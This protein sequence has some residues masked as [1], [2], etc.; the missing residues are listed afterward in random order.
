MLAPLVNSRTGIS[1]PSTK[2]R[3]G[4][5]TDT[6]TPGH[7]VGKASARMRIGWARSGTEC[8]IRS[9]EFVGRSSVIGRVAPPW[10]STIS[11]TPSPPPKTIRA[12]VAI[13]R[14]GC[15]ADHVCNINGECGIPRQGCGGGDDR[16]DRAAAGRHIG[17]D[18][19][20]RIELCPPEFER[21]DADCESECTK[22]NV[23]VDIAIPV[24]VR[25]TAARCLWQPR[26]RYRSGCSSRC[27][28]F[29][30]KSPSPPVNFTQTPEGISYRH[31]G[32]EEKAGTG[33]RQRGLRQ[34]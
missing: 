7:P 16:R 28:S 23:G 29:Q 20:S 10:V 14:A 32:L 5:E 13:T 17:L 30:A 6:V 2:N 33:A 26:F 11:P 9:K 22:R 18:G 24:K 34:P 31:V 3:I 1:R 27:N 19:R 25:L 15:K 12:A 8:R 21:A 4:P